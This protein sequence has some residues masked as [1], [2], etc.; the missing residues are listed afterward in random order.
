[1]SNKAAVVSSHSFSEANK[2]ERGNRDML[3]GVLGNPW[4]LQDGRV[5]VDSNPVAPGGYIPMVNPEVRG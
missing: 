4:N 3:L 1:M 5:E 2:E